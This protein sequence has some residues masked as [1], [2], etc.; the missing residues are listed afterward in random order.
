VN[1][2]RLAATHPAKAERFGRKAQKEPAAK[3]NKNKN[4]STGKTSQNRT[5]D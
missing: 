5:E 2:K 3:K 4:K 1:S